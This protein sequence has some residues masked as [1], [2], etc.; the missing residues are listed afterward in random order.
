[1]KK[2]IVIIVL[3]F[4]LYSCAT[5]FSS[6]Q[7][8]KSKKALN[9]NSHYTGTW[10]E[11]Y[12]N[13]QL[14]LEQEMFD[15]K[16]DGKYKRYYKS[17]K[18]H[19][20]FEI[21][22][23]KLVSAKEWDESGKLLVDGIFING[24]PFNGTFFSHVLIGG[25]SE[26]YL[27]EYQNGNRIKRFK[28]TGDVIGTENLVRRNPTVGDTVRNDLIYNHDILNKNMSDVKKILKMISHSMHF[29]NA[30]K[31]NYENLNFGLDT[32]KLRKYDAE[33]ATFNRKDGSQSDLCILIFHNG[34]EVIDIAAGRFLTE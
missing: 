12:D 25:S 6:N 16:L 15:G 28:I 23:G 22:N 10:K 29:E 7:K 32:L 11:W 5:N 4:F 9:E 31:I 24:H 2:L 3:S 34:E 17:G 27:D 20:E 1:M 13:G 21:K 30:K 8:Q 33:L 19:R 18:I 26:S 14:M